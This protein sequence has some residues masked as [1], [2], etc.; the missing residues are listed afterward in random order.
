M[1][2][3]I[4]GFG[5]FDTVAENPTAF[6]APRLAERCNSAMIAQSDSL[7]MPVSYNA[8][9]PI[10]QDIWSRQPDMLIHLGVA[11]GTER[12]Q[13][14]RVALNVQDARIPDIDGEQPKGTFIL[15]TEREA[16][17]SPLPL[18]DI[19]EKSTTPEMPVTVSHFAGTYLCNYVYFLSAAQGHTTKGFSTL[20]IHVPHILPPNPRFQHVE[21]A[22]F[23]CISLLIQSAKGL[24]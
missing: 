18:H 16:F 1:R 8:T 7:V 12:I 9:P 15:P 4:T 20:F 3:T 24:S 14:E 22:L 2:C 19:A 6:L 17:I 5:A 13:L 23:S 21:D 11:Q 10:L